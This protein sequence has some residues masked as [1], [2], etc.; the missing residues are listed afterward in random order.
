MTKFQVSITDFSGYKYVKRVF[1]DLETAKV[2]AQE[3]A[4]VFGDMNVYID[5]AWRCYGIHIKTLE[6]AP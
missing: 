3:L 2:H 6:S 4:D 5:A 1:C